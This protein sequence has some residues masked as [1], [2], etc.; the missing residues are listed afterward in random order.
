MALPCV[1]FSSSVADY[2]PKEFVKR[3]LNVAVLPTPQILTDNVESYEWAFENK[4]YSTS[5]HLCTT[6][7]RTIGDQDFAESVE[8]FVHYF[9]PN[10]LNSFELAK[11]WLPYLKH[12]EPEIQILVCECSRYTDVVCRKETLEWCIQNGFELVELSPENDEDEDDDF[13]ETTGMARIIQAL[14]AHTWPNMEMKDS[15]PVQ[16]PYL[17]Q[18]MK[19][20]HLI[21]QQNANA[22]LNSG[23]E[24]SAC[25]NNEDSLTEGV[26]CNSENQDTDTDL[27]SHDAGSET[28]NVKKTDM[29][30]NKESVCNNSTGAVTGNEENVQQSSNASTSNK[31]ADSGDSGG[32]SS[33][34]EQ[35]PL[36]DINWKALLA[37]SAQTDAPLSE[38]DIGVEEFE[39]LFMK[40]KVMKD[41]ADT[42][43][44]DERKKYAEKVAVSF[45]KA[46]GGDEDEILGLDD[47]DAD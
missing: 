42:M 19:E 38:D 31:S 43:P 12:I 1:L 27:S 40:L 47:S 23:S 37:D 18:M 22:V 35:M 46:I 29:S 15:P 11:A 39:Q 2:D 41:K 7:S 4:Y 17:R 20:Q 8:A 33:A 26:T 30:S 10:Q 45:W 34:N 3:I 25:E 6:D 13:P 9:D 21:N 14:N 16:S 36:D 24:T 32:G 28:D 5:V 44:V